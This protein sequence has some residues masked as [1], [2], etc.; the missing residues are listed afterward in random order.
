MVNVNLEDRFSGDDWRR[1]RT[2]DPAEYANPRDSKLETGA[3]A[4]RVPWHELGT[5][6]GDKLMTAKEAIAA[7]QLD[8]PVEAV[9]VVIP[10][11][12][13]KP[14]PNQPGIERGDL[15][16][17]PAPYL[18]DWN[19]RVIRRADD[20]RI[21]GY[22]SEDYHI[23]QNTEAFDFMDV[24]TGT[25]EAKYHTAGSL[26]MGEVV[27]LL[28]QMP[29][30]IEIVPGDTVQPF[31]LVANWH[32]PGRALQ[33]LITMER[34]VCWNTLNIALGGGQ[35]SNVFRHR[36]VMGL[37]DRANEA[38]E[39]LG[40]VE[41]YAK[42]MQHEARAL[43]ETAFSEADM[44][45]FSIILSGQKPDTKFEDLKPATQKFVNRLT[46]L[47]QTGY[48]QSLVP[49]T[50]WAAF[51]AVTQYTDWEARYRVN[52]REQA[53]RRIESAWFG[54]AAELKQEAYDYLIDRA[55]DG[56]PEILQLAGVE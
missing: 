34:V 17:A 14:T 9:P 56:R 51:N 13:E 47:Y 44:R 40:L 20:G 18:L 42:V 31:I 30:E 11:P 5:F 33:A 54:S 26:K 53:S 35:R 7:A 49:G 37:M 15:G 55:T 43:V 2:S 22:A 21:Y 3:F 19:H 27:F 16:G 46:S 45:T 1:R 32:K 23:T 4:V 12:V 29:Y 48:G 52:G 28:A 24:L 38:R 6:V 8:R 25:G 10:W 41:A 36:H 50:A 39:V